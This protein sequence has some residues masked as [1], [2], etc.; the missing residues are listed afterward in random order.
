MTLMEWKGHQTDYFSTTNDWLQIPPLNID[1]GIAAKHFE[2]LHLLVKLFISN[3][4]E[5]EWIE[6]NMPFF[7]PG[8]IS[9]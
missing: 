5:P 7:Y 6:V 1:A 2:W 4:R 9:Y 3:H 8:A